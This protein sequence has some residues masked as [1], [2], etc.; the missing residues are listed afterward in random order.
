MGGDGAGATGRERWG[1]SLVPSPGTSIVDDR[2]GG[3]A[4]VHEDLQGGIDGGSLGHDG[5]VVE[6]ADAQLLHRFLQEAWLGD[7]G[8]EDVEEL[9]DALVRQ[10]VQDIA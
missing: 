7:G 3:D 4:A 2:Q 5:H 9:E 1:G 10:D 8:A 6:R